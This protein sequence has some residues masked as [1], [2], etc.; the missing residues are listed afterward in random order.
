MS[1]RERLLLGVCMTSAATLVVLRSGML[2]RAK[3]PVQVIKP[4]VGSV[5][6][7]ARERMVSGPG[8]NLRT[9]HTA[10]SARS[11]NWQWGAGPKTVTIQIGDSSDC[12]YTIMAASRQSGRVTVRRVER[13]CGADVQWSD[14]ESSRRCFRVGMQ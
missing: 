7:V 14:A 11:W 12:Y 8:H 10:S 2:T 13:L 3:V 4:R 6:D 5:A 9:Q 1:T